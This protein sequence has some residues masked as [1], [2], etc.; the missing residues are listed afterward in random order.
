MIAIIISIL[1]LFLKIDKSYLREMCDYA[2]ST[3][4]GKTT[5][6]TCAANRALRWIWRFNGGQLP[7]NARPTSTAT[8]FFSQLRITG[9]GLGNIG[10]YSCAGYD[11]QDL[12]RDIVCPLHVQGKLYTNWNVFQ[13][14]ILYI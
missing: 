5:S 12:V 1:L 3:V 2:W 11:E 6:Y 9:A 4:S 10:N 8:S 13:L 14:L 7:N